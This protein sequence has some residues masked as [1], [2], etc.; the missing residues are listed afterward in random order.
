MKPVLILQHQT[1]E[2]PAYLVTWLKRYGIPYTTINAATG[3][4]PRAIDGYSALAV[5][6]GGMSANDPLDSNHRAQILI[7]QALYRDIPVIG[8]CLGGQLLARALGAEV[9]ESPAPEIGWG[10]IEWL[11][12]QETVSWFGKNPTSYVAQWHYEAF[13]LPA[14]A[15]RL[16]TS[17]ACPHQAF[18]IGKHLAMQF[19]IEIDI[20]KIHAWVDEGDSRWESLQGE[21]PTVQTR[22]Q[23]LDMAPDIIDSHMATADTVYRR[24]LETTGFFG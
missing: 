4:F 18:S 3:V 15:K 14:G 10:K 11:D 16:A 9:V 6:G 1:P 23:I 8:H 2:W 13:T 5:M 21:W 24:W 22:Q 12:S 7:L 20:K 17:S 19:H